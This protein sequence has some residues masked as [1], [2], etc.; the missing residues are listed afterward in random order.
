MARHR[1][2]PQ[3]VVRLRGQRQAHGVRAHHQPRARAQDLATRP[4]VVV[5]SFLFIYLVAIGHICCQNVAHIS[6]EYKQAVHPVF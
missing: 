6:V 4:S 2:L 3:E 5:D 1:L